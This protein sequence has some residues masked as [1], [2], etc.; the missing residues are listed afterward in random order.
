MLLDSTCK[1]GSAVV[2]KAGAVDQRLILRKSKQSRASI[3]WLRMISNCAC[4]DET[5]AE[6]GERL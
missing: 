1:C 4:F 6:G 3:A 2:I 5:E